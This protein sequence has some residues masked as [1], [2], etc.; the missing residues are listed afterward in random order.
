MYETTGEKNFKWL[1]AAR[2][3]Q[4]KS[5]SAPRF[6]IGLKIRYL[7]IFFQAKIFAGAAKLKVLTNTPFYVGAKAQPHKKKMTSS[8]FSLG[9]QG[10]RR[11]RSCRCSFALNLHK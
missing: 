7:Q 10:F 11:T 5:V 2:Q 3:V 6:Q 1:H 8:H 9:S 4:S